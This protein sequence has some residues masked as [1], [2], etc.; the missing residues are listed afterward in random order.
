MRQIVHTTG[1]Q[2]GPLGEVLQQ[3]PIGILVH[4]ALPRTLWIAKIYLQPRVG[5]RPGM[6]HCIAGY[7][8]KSRITTENQN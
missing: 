2:I 1:A 7:L 5:P 8:R 6:L 3:Q 4:A